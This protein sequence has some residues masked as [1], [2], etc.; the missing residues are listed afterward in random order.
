MRQPEDQGFVTVAVAGLIAVLLSVT[1][2]VALIGGVAVARHRAA[3][4][5]DL[6]A[7]AAATHA[8]EGPSAAC[9]AAGA[10]AVAHR[11][12]LSRCELLGSDATVE[13]RI[14]PR[15][16]LGRWGSARGVARAGPVP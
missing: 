15:G 10:V 13:V 6:A 5:A 11:A 14:S 12:Q 9:R 4:A 8:L 16:P 7:L 1:S 3:T 2:A